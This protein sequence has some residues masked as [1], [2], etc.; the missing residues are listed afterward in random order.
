MTANVKPYL[1]FFQSHI[2]KQSSRR[3]LLMLAAVI[4]LAGCASEESNT[5]ETP[6]S[7]PVGEP[8]YYAES[9]EVVSETVP[10][11]SETQVETMAQ[12]SSGI[13]TE[14][15]PV[16]S[17]KP[18][19][20]ATPVSIEMPAAG[21][22]ASMAA[23]S[24]TSASVTVSAT[25]TPEKPTAPAVPESIAW[26]VNANEIDFAINA[27]WIETGEPTSDKLTLVEVLDEMG[28]EFAIEDI[29]IITAQIDGGSLV[30]E[31]TENGESLSGEPFTLYK[32]RNELAYAYTEYTLYHSILE[33][34]AKGTPLT[35]EQ[36]NAL[37]TEIYF[38]NSE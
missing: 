15:A 31:G 23:S 2:L 3:A 22:E 17:S 28:Y 5:A 11:P 9:P 25:T 35:A 13:D 10:A 12:D 16:T 6:P 21:G 4:A 38:A 1:S 29:D 24:A 33:N 19:V 32:T 30:I 34:K 37:A 18:T 7:A 27:Y 8:T 20:E 14:A 26:M 36:I